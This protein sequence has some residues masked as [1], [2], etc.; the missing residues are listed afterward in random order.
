MIPVT[1]V[2][3]YSNYLNSPLKIAY[4]CPQDFKAMQDN[5]GKLVVTMNYQI[6]YGQDANNSHGIN[7]HHYVMDGHNV[8]G[9]L[10]V[11]ESSLK[12]EYKHT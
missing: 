5:Q 10:R 9:F 6:P 1:Q 2:A 12:N 3:G 11:Q 8:I 4:E 7:T